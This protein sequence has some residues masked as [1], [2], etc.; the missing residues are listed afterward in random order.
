[1]EALTSAA[2]SRPRWLI[3]VAV[4]GGIALLL[5]LPLVGSYNAMVD[6]EA[7]V[8]RTFADLDAQLQRRNDLIPNLVNAVRGALNQ[9][10]NVFGEIA[11]ARQ[12]YAGAQTPAQ[13]DAAASEMSGAFGRL[14]VV[15]EAY[16]QLQSNQN[17]RD[18]QTQI[19]GTENRIVQARREYNEK[20]IDFNRS[21]RR[22]PRSI[23]AG[24]FGF[25]KRAEFTA[26]PAARTAPTVDL[27]NST[28]T[29]TR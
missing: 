9:E 26:E 27:G 19:E 28:T 6:K 7:E 5:I 24:L 23:F 20:V 1:M 3:P 16:P 15:M 21:I 8:D 14:L 17:I 22:F 4:I 29:T 18:L 25:E 12:N 13:K 10:V 2:R 11:R